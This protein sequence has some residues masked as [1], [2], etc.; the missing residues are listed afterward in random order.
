MSAANITL[1]EK[2]H[3]TR[4]ALVKA[5]LDMTGGMEALYRDWRRWRD[6][7]E[8]MVPVDSGDRAGRPQ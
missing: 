4:K 5:R 1:E 2:Y 8:S 3:L 6:K 7:L